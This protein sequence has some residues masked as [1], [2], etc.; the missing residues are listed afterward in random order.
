M[1]AAQ[2]GQ[3]H[4]H[5][6]RAYPEEG[7]GVLL[8]R[9]GGEARVIERVLPF[10]NTRSEERERRYL[11]A[12]EQL[13]SAERE[14]REAGLD[15]VGFFHSHPDHPAVPSAFD[16]EHAWPYYSY[17]IVSVERGKVADATSWRL[18]ADRSGFEPEPIETMPAR[19]TT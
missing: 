6:C 3:I 5:L 7:C 2:A 10:Q 11:I 4:A 16:L 19:A 1:R 18:A 17:L 15:V 13:L 8:G 9:D 14:A 12:P